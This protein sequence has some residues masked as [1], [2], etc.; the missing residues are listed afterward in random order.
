MSCVSQGSVPLDF[1]NTTDQFK[2]E[3]IY[4]NAEEILAQFV[5]SLNNNNI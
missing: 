4:A 1:L 5:V 2:A 3:A